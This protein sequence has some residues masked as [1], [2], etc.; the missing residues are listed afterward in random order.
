[1]PIIGISSN[2]ILVIIGVGL[3]IF[4]HELGHFLVA[5]KVGVRVYA[6][7]LGFGP[8]L[9]R[10]Q[11][12][13]TDYRISLIPLGGYVKLAGEQREESNTGEDW[14][15]M[16]KKPWQRAAVLVAGVTCNT[17]LAFVAFKSLQTEPEP[18]HL[19]LWC[20]VGLR[21]YEYLKFPPAG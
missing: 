12:G 13:E 3:L 11:I 1:M 4:V 10:K 14:E 6:F 2:V 18:W 21:Q 20:L 5:K 7:S 9:I 15:F 8:A 17:L 16:S 19:W